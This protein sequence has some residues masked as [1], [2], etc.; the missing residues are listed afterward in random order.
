[1]KRSPTIPVPARR[2]RQNRCGRR[3]AIKE[4]TVP[5]LVRPAHV[6]D[7]RGMPRPP[8][9]LAAQAMQRLEPG[10]VL[11]VLTEPEFVAGLHRWAI[12]SGHSLVDA[13][14]YGE[15]FH[16]LLRRN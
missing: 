9:A 10:Q 6:L 2:L 5:L 3:A 7:C 8:L 12:R 15:D 13:D 1:M 14:P 11:L 4:S 16:V